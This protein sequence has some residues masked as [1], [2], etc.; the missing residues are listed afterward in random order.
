MG[1][2]QLSAEPG[3]FF[4]KWC[5]QMLRL[6]LLAGDGAELSAWLSRS[7]EWSHSQQPYPL[8]AV[9]DLAFGSSAWRLGWA[10]LD[11]ATASGTAKC[12]AQ[13]PLQ[14]LL[15]QA[16]SLSPSSANGTGLGI[17]HHCSQQ[18]HLLQAAPAKCRAWPGPAPT[19]SPASGAR[20]TGDEAAESSTIC[21][22]Y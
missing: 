5:C 1:Q 6:A 12:Q 21:R 2:C 8:Q 11:E 15:S 20:F 22:T 13:H 4:C 7:C 10:R 14:D 16:P 17:W 9:L 3:P 19:L 18:P